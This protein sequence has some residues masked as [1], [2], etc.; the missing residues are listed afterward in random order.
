MA[1]REKKGG[2]E[3]LSVREKKCVLEKEEIKKHV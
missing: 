2:A 3:P 1:D